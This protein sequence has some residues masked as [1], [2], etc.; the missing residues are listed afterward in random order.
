MD[1][2]LWFQMS[3]LDFLGV[4]SCSTFRRHSLVAF[5]IVQLVKHRIAGAEGHECLA[6]ADRFAEELLER[7]ERG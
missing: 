1:I 5:D 7:S 4:D 2:L 6:V 3:I